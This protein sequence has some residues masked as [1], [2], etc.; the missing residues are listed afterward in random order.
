[1]STTSSGRPRPF[2]LIIMDGWGVGH[3]P[4]A[5]AISQAHP[6]FVNSLYGKYPHSELVTCG[7]AV[8]LPEQPHSPNCSGQIPLWR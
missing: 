1:M 8:G 2:V 7:E 4:Q 5:D 3:V 6:E